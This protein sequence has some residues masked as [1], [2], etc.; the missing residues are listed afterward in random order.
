MTI[1]SYDGREETVTVPFMIAGNPV[2][3]IGPEVFAK[4]D[5]VKVVYLPN[6]VVEIDDTAFSEKQTVIYYNSESEDSSEMMGSSE[7]NSAPAEDKPFGEW[8]D[9]GLVD[10]SGNLITVDDEGHLIMVDTDMVEWIL[11]DTMEFSKESDD[12]GDVTILAE[13]GQEIELTEGEII[14]YTDGNQD[15][16]TINTVEGTK[17][18]TTESDTVTVQITDISLDEEESSNDVQLSEQTD[19]KADDEKA[20]SSSDTE[21]VA[22]QKTEDKNS[23]SDTSARE[24]SEGIADKNEG[25][26]KGN[27]ARIVAVVSAVLLVIVLICAFALEKKKKNK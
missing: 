19:P 20:A 23:P 27:T 18:F 24:E 12:T 15:E 2:N 11:D 16:V 10:D 22:D 6:S 17:T 26:S 14:S 7:Q 21:E 4:N 3:T 13:D 25:Q 9:L 8:S 5:A 1:I